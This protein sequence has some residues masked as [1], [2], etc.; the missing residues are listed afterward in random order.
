MNKKLIQS[1]VDNLGS[2]YVQ[3]ERELKHELRTKPS[4]FEMAYELTQLRNAIAAISHA[5]DETL[6]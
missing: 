4:R 6:S 5:I 1:R 3:L 2:A